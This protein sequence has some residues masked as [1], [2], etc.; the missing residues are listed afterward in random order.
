NLQ[1]PGIPQMVDFSC[2]P[3]KFKLIQWLSL[4]CLINVPQSIIRHECEVVSL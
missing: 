2:L 4:K 3:Y 1:K